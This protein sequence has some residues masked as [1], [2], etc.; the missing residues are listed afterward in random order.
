MRLLHSSNLTFHEIFDEDIPNYPYAILSHRWGS[1]ADEV[2]YED[3]ITGKKG[4]SYG[5][6][7]IFA[8]CEWA[9][10]NNYDWVWVDTCC[11]DKRSSAELS[12]AINSMFSWYRRSGVCVVYLRDTTSATQDFTQDEWFSR[13][14]TLQE[15]IAPHDVQFM[16]GNWETIGWKNETHIA[17]A[18]NIRTGIPQRVLLD[19]IDVKNIS[20]ARRMSWMANRRTTKVEDMAYCLLGIFDVN[21]PLLYGEGWKAFQR[22]QL[23]IMEQYEDESIFAW[24]EQSITAADSAVHGLLAKQPSQFA[25]CGNVVAMRTEHDANAHSLRAN[26]RNVELC[27]G[28]L[29]AE[30]VVGDS[31]EVFLHRLRCAYTNNPASYLDVYVSDSVMGDDAIRPCFIALSRKSKGDSFSRVRARQLPWTLAAYQECTLLAR[32][33]RQSFRARTS[34]SVEAIIDRV[35]GGGKHETGRRRDQDPNN[36]SAPARPFIDRSAPAPQT[37]APAR[38]AYHGQAVDS[39]PSANA[40]PS[41]ESDDTWWARYNSQHYPPPAYAPSPEWVG[42]PPPPPLPPRPNAQSAQNPPRNAVSHNTLSH[43]GQVRSAEP[44]RPH[45]AS[46]N[47]PPPATH[48]HS[49]MRPSDQPSTEPK[50]IRWIEIRPSHAP[51]AAYGHGTYNN[52]STN[53][54]YHVPVYGSWGEDENPFGTACKTQCDRRGC[55]SWKANGMAEKLKLSADEWHLYAARMLQA[56]VDI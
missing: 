23:L 52:P 25:H 38:A 51:H 5:Y 26:A 44:P 30:S 6:Q 4:D 50:E 24:S 41:R 21:M 3:F 49:A 19:Q 39:N 53:G 22:L 9:S 42:S 28:L 47:L 29:Q 31:N 17:R 34:F 16:N 55:L 48:P 18:V 33:P 8:F 12:E 11:I 27:A 43:G 1:L 2:S 20:V 35:F 45:P 32:Q 40:D 37:S 56:G 54:S 13:G 46:S 36:V 10:A 7:K 14:W 15:L